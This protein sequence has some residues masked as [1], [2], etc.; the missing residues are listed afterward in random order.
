LV[1]APL[2]GQITLDQRVVRAGDIDQ[3]ASAKLS[4]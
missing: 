2:P 3:L 1:E 4:S